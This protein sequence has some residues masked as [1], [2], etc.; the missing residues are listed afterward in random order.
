VNPVIAIDGPAASGKSTVARRVAQ[1][2]GWV[3][4]DTGAMYR[5]VT[6]Q[7]LRKGIAPTDV[8]HVVD[9]LQTMPFLCEIENGVTVLTCEERIL[10]ENLRA[11]EV[12]QS[13]SPVAAIPAV[14]TRL[15]NVQRCLLARASLV[16]EGRD[17]GSTV[18]P[19]TPFKFYLDASV[20]VREARRASQG[21]DDRIALRDKIDSSRAVAPLQIALGAEVIDTSL[22]DADS[23]ARHILRKVRSALSARY[24]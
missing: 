4:V 2:L 13:V 5:A 16:M 17:I 23:V 19:D 6:W 10:P 12:A 3:Y 21:E 11:T 22:H 15:V 9:Y 8:D 20:S 24:A 7:V 1:E 18:F 14:R